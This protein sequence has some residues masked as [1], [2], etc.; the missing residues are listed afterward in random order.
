MTWFASIASKALK[1]TSK[2]CLRNKALAYHALKTLKI[3]S[4][5]SAPYIRPCAP[6]AAVASF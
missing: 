5:S 3:Y 2:R 4:L 6:Y 1:S